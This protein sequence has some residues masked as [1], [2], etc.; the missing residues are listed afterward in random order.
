VLEHLLLTPAPLAVHRG[1]TVMVPHPPGGGDATED[2]PDET[3]WSAA[4]GVVHASVEVV[5]SHGEKREVR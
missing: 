5:R 4:E 2:K 1:A 3:R